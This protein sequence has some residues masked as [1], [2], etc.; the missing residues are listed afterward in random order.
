MVK[1]LAAV[2]SVQTGDGS[3][4]KTVPESQSKNTAEVAEVDL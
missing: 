1:H 4:D 2:G 3:R